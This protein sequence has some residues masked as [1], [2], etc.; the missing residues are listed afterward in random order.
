MDGRVGMHMKD[1]KDQRHKYGDYM[2]VM[3]NF[4]HELLGYLSEI[5]LGGFRIDTPKA[6]AVKRDY[7]L[8]LEYTSPVAEK[9]YIVLV[10][11]VKWLQPDPITPNEY[12]AGFQIVSISPPEHEIY[13]SIVDTYGPPKHKW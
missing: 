3:D 6:L 4:T 9:P 1:R 10:A 2:R 7:T 12:I 13:R 8:R 5:S 11:R